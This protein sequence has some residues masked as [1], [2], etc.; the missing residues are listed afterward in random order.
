MK[1]FTT[2]ARQGDVLLTALPATP[3]GAKKQPL[4]SHEG[5]YRVAQSTQG[6]HHVIPVDAIEEISVHGPLR[7][8]RIKTDTALE[9]QK[10][11]G[12]EA[13]ALKAGVTYEITGQVE[14]GPAGL[15]PVVD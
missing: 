6:H 15:R 4:L 8:I 3:P 11:G 14:V 13:L 5:R 10:A 9:H 1:T 7:Y 2:Q 12:H